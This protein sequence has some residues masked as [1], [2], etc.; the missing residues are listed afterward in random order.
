M[1][2]EL[3]SLHAGHPPRDCRGPTEPELVNQHACDTAGMFM[4]DCRR[5]DA[6]HSEP[7]NTQ[8]F[9]KHQILTGPQVRKAPRSIE[10]FR[11]AQ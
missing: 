2:H 9:A 6:S 10:R 7:G 4:R 8:S 1:A 11:S 5:F 3:E